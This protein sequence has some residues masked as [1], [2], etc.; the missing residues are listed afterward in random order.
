[1][2]RSGCSRLA[3]VVN[4]VVCTPLKI[5]AGRFWSVLEPAD[6]RFERAADEHEPGSMDLTVVVPLG[7]SAHQAGDSRAERVQPKWPVRPAPIPNGLPLLLTES[8][9]PATER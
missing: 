6:K 5:V 1:M 9:K 2:S 7:K 3:Y 8:V 4:Q